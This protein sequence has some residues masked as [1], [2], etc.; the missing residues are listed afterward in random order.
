MSAKCP[1]AAIYG[2]TWREPRHAPGAAAPAPPTVG[3]LA[4]GACRGIEVQSAGGFEGVRFSATSADAGL[5]ADGTIF[6]GV[7][8]MAAA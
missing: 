2:M 4:P 3:R 6:S 8:V 1:I 5:L 7:A